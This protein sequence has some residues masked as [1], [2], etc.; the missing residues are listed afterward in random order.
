MAKILQRKPIDLANDFSFL[1][2]DVSKTYVCKMLQ[3]L[4][5][6]SKALALVLKN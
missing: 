5:D 6:K 2:S 3:D 1:T 4:P